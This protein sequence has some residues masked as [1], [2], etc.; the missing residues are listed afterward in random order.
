MLLV[1]EPHFEKE[2]FFNHS[3]GGSQ[4]KGCVHPEPILHLEHHAPEIPIPS[5]PKPA[6][7]VGT[8][9]SSRSCLSKVV[10]GGSLQE[11]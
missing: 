4:E 5:S 8:G 1:Q 3:A 10:K 6:S 2:P 11:V 7:R 9:L